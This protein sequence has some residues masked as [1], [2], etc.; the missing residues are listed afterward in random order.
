MSETEAYTG[1]LKPTG[2]TLKEVMDDQIFPSYYDKND[3]DDVNEFFMDLFHQ[4]MILVNGMVY[5]VEKEDKSDGDIFE[6]TI[7]ENGNIKFT[8]Q[9]YNGGCSF[10]EAIEEALKVK[11]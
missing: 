8:V 2:K 6:S 3:E 11:K 4:D 1:V 10:D 7:L 9:Y 5:E